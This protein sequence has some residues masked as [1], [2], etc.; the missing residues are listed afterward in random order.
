MDEYWTAWSFCEHGIAL[1]LF[2]ASK[3]GGRRLLHTTPPMGTSQPS[4]FVLQDR[5][6]HLG[7]TRCVE[8]P[9][10]VPR[11]ASPST[12]PPFLNPCMQHI[13]GCSLHGRGG[14]RNRAPK[15]ILFPSPRTR[16]QL[17][18]R[19]VC[20]PGVRTTTWRGKRAHRNATCS[21]AA[22]MR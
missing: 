14:L 10:V 9:R 7:D 13:F 6:T 15:G 22:P 4:H 12:S 8:R 20:V 19:H 18:R 21:V 17:P 16:V 2:Y 11:D 3:P 5:D 1:R